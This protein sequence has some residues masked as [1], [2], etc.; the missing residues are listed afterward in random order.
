MLSWLADLDMQVVMFIDYTQ[1]KAF[2]PVD[3][4]LLIFKRIVDHIYCEA[5]LV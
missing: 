4:P 3:S 2:A 5:N 1:P